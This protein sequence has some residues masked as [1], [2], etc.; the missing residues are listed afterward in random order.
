MNTESGQENDYTIIS[1]IILFL[2]F[3]YIVYKSKRKIHIKMYNLDHVTNNDKYKYFSFTQNGFFYILKTYRE[4]TR[5]ELYFD[6]DS[7][8]KYKKALKEYIFSDDYKIAFG[9]LGRNPKR[10]CK[11]NGKFI[12]Y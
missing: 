12:I 4:D 2:A 1:Y 7:K 10:A 11:Y 3:L 6:I 5:L 9:N 8:Y